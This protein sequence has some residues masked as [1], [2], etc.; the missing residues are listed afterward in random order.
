MHLKVW[1]SSVNHTS[2]TSYPEP[3]KF[4]VFSSRNPVDVSRLSVVSQTLA[5]Q[6]SV[7]EEKMTNSCFLM[8]SATF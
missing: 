7:F 8:I 5:E 3:G 4:E 2:K 1:A 6:K